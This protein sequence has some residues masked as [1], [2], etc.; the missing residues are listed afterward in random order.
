M[1]ASIVI[2]YLKRKE[3]MT[4]LKLGAIAVFVLCF[5]WNIYLLVMG[6]TPGIALILGIFFLIVIGGGT[7]LITAKNRQIAEHN[8]EVERNNEQVRARRTELYSR[9][10]KLAA[11]M[12]ENSSGWFPP[13]YY[14]IEAVDFFIRA[15]QNYRAESVKEMV[16]L[17]E[18]NEQFKEMAAYQKQ[19]VD[20]LN[21]LIDGQQEIIGQLRFTN[22]M[23]VANF[24]QLQGINSNVKEVNASVKNLNKT[25]NKIYTEMPRRRR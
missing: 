18:Q 20:R 5:C 7:F 17:F 13:N 23:Q 22:M 16:N 11:E 15:V 19:Q 2:I 1:V 6:M 3:K 12:L 14:A 9:Y 4:R 25:A 8:K 24:I 21:Q 10:E